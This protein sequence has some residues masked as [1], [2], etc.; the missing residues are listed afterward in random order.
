MFVYGKSI[1][2]STHS[3]YLGLNVGHVSRVQVSISSFLFITAMC[4]LMLCY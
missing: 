4:L 1:V 3:I 2:V